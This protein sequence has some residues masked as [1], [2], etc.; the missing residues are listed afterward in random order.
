MTL[1]SNKVDKGV[2]RITKE[3]DVLGETQEL[4]FE[5]L[6]SN[7]E[8]YWVLNDIG[9]GNATFF[10][11]QEEALEAIHNRTSNFTTD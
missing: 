7:D 5:L 1:K 4:H 10:E 8:N 6:W 3:F 11:T 9:A 2:Y